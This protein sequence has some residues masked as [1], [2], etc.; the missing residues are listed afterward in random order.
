MVWI[1]RNQLRIWAENIRAA[2]DQLVPPG[3][4]AASDQEVASLGDES[5]IE[6]ILNVSPATKRV[7]GGRS[8]LMGVADSLDS[9]G[10]PDAE[11]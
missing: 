4:L 7:L 6:A 9:Y 8:T 10:N 3:E 1:N 2:V 5:S 11:R